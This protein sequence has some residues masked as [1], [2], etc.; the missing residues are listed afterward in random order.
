MQ[1]PELL[2]LLSLE[3]PTAIHPEPGFL[4]ITGMAHYE[5]VNSRIYAY[6]LDQSKHREL[7]NSFVESLQKIIEEKLNKT[8]EL[9]DYLVTNEEL[10]KKNYRIDI[11][12]N[13]QANKSAI[14]IE[15]KIY[16]YLHNDLEDYWDH[17]K[18]PDENKLGVLLTLYPHDIPKEVK[19]K[20]VNITH[21]EWVTKI[22]ANGL[23]SKLPTK[24]YT[25]LNDFFETIDSL[26]KSNH[27][28]D[29]A[30]F[31]FQH[32]KQVIKAQ[33][34]Q[35]EAQ[36]FLANQMEKLAGKLGWQVYGGESDRKNIWD[37]KND[38]KTYYT[39]VYGP[40]LNGDGHIQIIIELHGDDMKQ[41]DAL[42]TI[43]KGNKK[44]EVMKRGITSKWNIHFACRP[45][46][47]D[48]EKIEN[49]A[50]TVFQIIKDDFDDVMK[51][52]LKHNYPHKSLS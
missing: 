33:E 51:I 30:K 8:I 46:T 40:L 23:P 18:Y 19:G 3:I 44:F 34:T 36:N 21:Q 47:L 31:Y 41:V 52:I 38:L 43:L 29:Q 6:F 12:L 27:M 22:Q 32:A 7:A 50:D 49:F 14:L 16:H 45:Y 5:N 2:Q 20:F 1:D 28:N 42:D 4:E 35:S 15:N 13:D 11:T 9:D 10:T 39:I 24:I 37:Q 26:T 48:I 17:Y 25:Y